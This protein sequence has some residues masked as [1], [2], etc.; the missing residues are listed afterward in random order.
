MSCLCDMAAGQSEED[1]LSVSEFIGPVEHSGASSA[2]APLFSPSLR[3][4]A[5][6]SASIFWPIFPVNCPRSFFAPADKGVYL[7]YVMCDYIWPLTAQ[8]V[9]E[10]TRRRHGNP[11]Q[12][13]V[14][15][16]CSSPTC[17]NKCFKLMRRDQT[18]E[19]SML[20]CFLF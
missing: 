1:T 3:S 13:S 19:W 16:R 8:R 2:R 10:E 4:A 9:G 15:R 18:L 11:V 7:L 6:I 20:R 17:K 14:Y 5:F 12:G